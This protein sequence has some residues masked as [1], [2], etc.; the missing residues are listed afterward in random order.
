V[1]TPVG[2]VVE[3]L[4]L[5]EPGP[6]IDDNR[7]AVERGD[8]ECEQFRGETLSRELQTGVEKRRARSREAALRESATP[9][10]LTQPALGRC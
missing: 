7:P 3:S 6:L 8:L 2:A 4:D 10:C 9:N 1:E 5:D